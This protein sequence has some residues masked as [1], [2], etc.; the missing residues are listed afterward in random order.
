MGFVGVRFVPIIMRSSVLA[1]VG[2]WE[3][4]GT[5]LPNGL[6]GMWWGEVVCMRLCACTRWVWRRVASDGA[7]LAKVRDVVGVFADSRRC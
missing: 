7:D 3:Q 1:I 5:I 6:G 4:F 2:Y